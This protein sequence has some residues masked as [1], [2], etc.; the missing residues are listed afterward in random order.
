[1]RNYEL[2]VVLDGKATKAQISE[3]KELI[4]K[5]VKLFEG[6]IVKQEDWGIKDLAY[7]IK[8]CATGFFFYSDIEIPAGKV[9][10]LNEKLRLEE[11]IIRFLL[12]KSN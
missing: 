6:K 9:K 11:G 10:D 12:V 7:S 2:T 5:L 3:K 1:M 8:K 4:E